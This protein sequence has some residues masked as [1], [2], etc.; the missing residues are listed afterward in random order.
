MFPQSLWM[1]EKRLST[2]SLE[3]LCVR[4]FI[5]ENRLSNIII[6]ALLRVLNVITTSRD[7]FGTS[8]VRYMNV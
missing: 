7:N 2:I 8:F 1:F 3:H 4:I 6:F 5:F